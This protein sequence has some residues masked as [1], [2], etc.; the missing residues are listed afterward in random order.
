[1][2]GCRKPRGRPT[3]EAAAVALDQ[4]PREDV[5]EA[6]IATAGDGDPKRTP[7]GLVAVLG[8]YR[9]KHWDQALCVAFSPDG[10]MLATAGKDGLVKL[11]PC[12]LGT[13]AT[14]ARR[15][16]GLGLFRGL[17]SRRPDAGL[18]QP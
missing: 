5:P 13:P 1:M 9:F 3:C 12:P 16:Q 2:P 8:D 11:W 6:E 7:A 14:A 17:Q 18:R 15:A 10:K 4:L